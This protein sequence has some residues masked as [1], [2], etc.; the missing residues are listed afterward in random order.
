MGML[1]TI[2]GYFLEK[3]EGFLEK[4]IGKTAAKEIGFNHEK[5][6]N[7]G[8]IDPAAIAGGILGSIVTVGSNLEKGV[9]GALTSFVF[10]SKPLN[11]GESEVIDAFQNLPHDLQLK[12]ISDSANGS[13]G[14]TDAGY[15]FIP[16]DGHWYAVAPAPFYGQF[17]WE[18]QAPAV[19]EAQLNQITGGSTPATSSGPLYSGYSLGGSTGSPSTTGGGTPGETGNAIEWVDNPSALS[20]GTPGTGTY[21]GLSLGGYI[22]TISSAPGTGTSPA[23]NNL[24]LGYGL[25]SSFV[26]Q[27]GTSGGGSS[28]NPAD[29]TIEACLEPPPSA[30]ASQGAETYGPPIPSDYNPSPAPYVPQQP[31]NPDTNTSGSTPD[32]SG[33]GDQV[34]YDPPPSPDTGGGSSD[35][36]VVL[37][38]SGKGIKITPLGSSNIYMDGKDGLEHRIAWGGAGNGVLVLDPDGSTT[39]DRQTIFDFTTLDPTATSDMQALLDVAD[40]NHDG[41]LDAGDALFS[42]FRVLVT[43]ADGTTTLE[44]LA[45]AGVAAINLTTNH[46]ATTLADGSQILGETSFSPTNPPIL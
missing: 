35:G 14:A 39:V 41:S 37:D 25:Q 5:D 15:T 7:S 42:Q 8:P 45:Q 11:D 23:L 36:P 10:N 4:T 16:S 31:A 26:P 12:A 2:A 17:A 27:S 28:P 44:T 6:D 29:N 3:T 20:G 19:I 32:N 43:N 18:K 22:G 38:L 13:Y 21:S 30:P 33:G 34:A 24:L 9:G 46:H 1:Q 40:T